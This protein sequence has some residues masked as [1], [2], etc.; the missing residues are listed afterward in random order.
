[1]TFSERWN[2][3]SFRLPA[4][5]ALFA[6]ITG[7]VSGSIAYYVAYDSYVD[8]AKERMEMVRNERIRA[9][10]T[11]INDTRIGLESLASRPGLGHD[12]DALA[13]TFAKLS[14]EQRSSL[15]KRYTTE[16]PFPED[17][18]SALSDA[19]DNSIFST[20]HKPIH[21]RLL[22]MQQIKELEDILLVDARG[23][24][25]YSVKK[26]DDFGTNLLTGPYRDSNA[27]TVF[28][29]ALATQSADNPTFADMQAYGPQ[30]L[31]AM[32]MAL[33]I[34]DEGKI[35]GAMLMRLNNQKLRDV[36]N[37]IQDLG[38]TGEVYLVGHDH[39]RRSHTRFSTGELLTE[40]IT[41]TA[42][43]RSTAGF[44]ESTITI[45]YKG[46]KAV[47][48][49]APIDLM[50]V[51]W[52][53]ISKIELREALAPLR[54]MAT[55]ASLGGLIA[56]VF[57]AFFGYVMA[58]R[59]SYPLDQSLRA[60]EKLAQGNLDVQI[61]EDGHIAETRKI[62]TAL[63][64]FHANL[65]ET[66]RL[67]SEVE[68]ALVVAT[69]ERARAEA[70]LA[71]A[72]DPI[73]LVRADSVIEYVNAQV[74]RVLGYSAG[75]LVGERLETLIPERFRV[76]HPS[77]VRG[78]FESGKLRQMG[79]GRELF[80]RKKDGSELPVEIALSPIRAGEKAV[81][82]ALIRDITDQKA[83]EKAVRLAKE[84]AEAATEAKSNFLASMSHEIRTPMNGVTGMA[85][86]LA[87]TGLDDEQKH[88]VRTIRESGNALITVINDI[89]DFSKIE[90]GKL[91]LE[92]VTMS[93]V[94][95]VEGVASTL[96]P[97]A[98]K[99]GVRVHV[100]VDPKLP[101]FVHGDPTRLRQ[102]LFNLGGNAVKFSNGKDVQIRVTAS[103]RVD[104][105][106]I[107]LRFAVIDHGIGISK[108]NQAKLFQAFMQAESSTTRRFGGT[109]LGL[110]ICKR[111]TEMMNG[112]VSVESDEGRG[113]TFTVELPFA[114]DGEAKSN[115][116][117]RDLHGL[118][119]L[120]VGSE[121][122]RSDAIE[123]YLRHWGADVLSVPDA[124]TA[125]AKLTSA[126]TFTCIMIDLGLDEARQERALP[127]LRKAAAKTPLILLQ[128][129]QHRGARIVGDDV[130]TIDATP[131]IRYR[132]VSAVA[133]AA[134]RASPEIKSDVDL[135]AVTRAKAPTV[136]EAL[137][138]GQLILLAEDNLTNQ[139][140]IRRQ[141]K[142]VGYT[143]E[144][145][146]NGAE[147][148]AAYKTGRYALLLTDCH[149]PEMDGYELT[150]AIRTAEKGSGQHLP[151]IA[152]T[153]NALQGEAERCLASGMDD[154]ISKPIAMP[155]LANALKKWMP[156]PREAAKP[157]VVDLDQAP[158]TPAVDARAIKD[159]FGDDDTIFKEILQSFVEPSQE[160]IVEIMVA[161]E[162]KAAADVKSAAHKLKSAA[163][164]VGANTL[165][166][167][168]VALETA[169]K[170]ADWSTIDA[171]A[172][173]A[174]AEFT[175]VERYIKRL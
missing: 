167:L 112:T 65:I 149:M 74:E 95:A 168:C 38:N 48:A 115:L 93:V 119:V 102:V 14:D 13:D 125:A 171:L 83:A 55:A 118:N 53:I 49:Y 94:D 7:L 78:F 43:L 143:C 47:S 132:V 153:A 1:M 136:E 105:G 128:D 10:T 80:A 160:I 145:M 148:L 30:A 85:D 51:R 155:A 138:L 122:P 91:D 58:R 147:A 60:M 8:L 12:L 139:D 127:A 45:D 19:N 11:L 27:A 104:Q 75:E 96:T 141:L 66:K 165:A 129:Y 56:I 5:I 28:R 82:V 52:G 89:L 99:K 116:K 169:G 15:V 61:K 34:R 114:I 35:A 140:V 36:A 106:K 73:L 173:K 79:A 29:G 134:G 87:Q 101:A 44:T 86:L 121:Q 72:P 20:L 88:M 68:S 25:V 172:P 123:T 109:G 157:I 174:R 59:I 64:A 2:R 111:L 158:Q 162:K 144:V 31:P 84:A 164:S 117:E 100:Y 108:E 159:V 130:V 50:G 37:H 152:V 39:T 170:N 98:T 23:N 21:E 16:N 9:V 42:V 120:L 4:L 92:D 113:S 17:S 161:W 110:A 97:N 90:A 137:A 126:A 69:N 124:E 146:S 135:V 71:G 62:T 103:S 57:I 24:I 33:A 142:L 81:V 163:R 54:T 150:G 131:L 133:V 6:A 46:D 3:L 32:F 166:D 18:R 41:T 63:R 70:I 40:K 67:Q 154:Y 76:G 26:H 151:I 156:P 107:W 77:Q 175:E 22:R